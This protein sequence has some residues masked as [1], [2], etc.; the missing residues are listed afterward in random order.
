MGE[1]LNL[2]WHLLNSSALIEFGSRNKGYE[3]V[4]VS[5]S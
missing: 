4:K 2:K 3:Q 1:L 5:D